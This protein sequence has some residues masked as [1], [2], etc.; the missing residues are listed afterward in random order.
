MP[1]LLVA[2]GGSGTRF[3]SPIPKQLLPLAGV[4]VLRRSLL[5]FAGLV[6]EAV[7]AA[8]A[9]H[10]AA[11]AEACA[12]LPFPVR[13]VEGGPSRQASVH[14]ALL[15]SGG[16]PC[17]VH[18][19][20][21]PFVPRRCIEA[22][23]AALARHPAAVV[24]V[25][26]AAT[27]KRAAPDGSVAATVPRRDLWLAQTPQGFRR[28]AGLEAFARA[29]REGW[30]CTDDA[31]VLERAGHPVVLVPGDPVNLKITEPGDW[32]LA[33]ALLRAGLAPV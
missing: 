5:P 33:E 16:D 18:D 9:A 11:V 28:Q 15:A 21:R 6:E 23:L 8:P 19:A 14:A 22:C 3:G 13:V 4:P 1:S 31:E 32:R 17:L 27:V 12:G 26:C 2:A 20:V 29:A 25:P 30:Q 7:V 10:S 24:A